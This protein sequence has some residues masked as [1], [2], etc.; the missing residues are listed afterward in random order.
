[1]DTIVSSHK[2]DS[3]RRRLKLNRESELGYWVRQ[4]IRAGEK[5]KA[6]KKKR[7]EES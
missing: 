6:R 3:K 4:W 5:R 1:M 7:Q 2:R